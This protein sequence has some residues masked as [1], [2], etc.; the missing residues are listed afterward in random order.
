VA[1][2]QVKILIISGVIEKKPEGGWKYSK[3]WPLA[4]KI[5]AWSLISVPSSWAVLF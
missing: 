5:F 4:F 2:N 3:I 1:K